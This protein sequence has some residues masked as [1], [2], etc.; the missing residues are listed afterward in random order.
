V[1]AIYAALAL[2]G[3]AAGILGVFVQALRSTAGP[4]PVRYGVAVAV[5]GAVG[6]FALGRS[7]TGSRAGVIVPAS[8]WF[9]AILPF[10]IT[11]PEG[12]AVLS[13]N[14]PGAY[15]FL[16]LPTLA[17]QHCDSAPAAAEAAALKPRRP[18]DGGS[19]LGWSHLDPLGSAR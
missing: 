8:A 15:L 12:D 7:V 1:I 13:G 10:T 5:A 14:G 6:L 16:A 17:R 2:G 4:I 11:R 18:P 3:L 9:L 19:N